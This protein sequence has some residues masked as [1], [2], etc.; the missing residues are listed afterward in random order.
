MYS[1]FDLKMPNSFYNSII[2]SHLESGIKIYNDLE[3]SSKK[4]L[5]NFIYD[6]GHIDGS[7]LKKHWFNIQQ[8]DIFISHSHNDINKVKA[9]AGWL[10]DI[11]GLKSFIDSCV[12]G[13]CNDLLKQI[14]DD[15]CKKKGSN[16]Y[17]YELR[18]YTTSHVHMMLSIA[19]SEMI[20]NAE[21]VIFYNTP[22][23]VTLKSDL[24][25]IN[26]STKVVTMSP[27]IYHELAMTTFI[28]K[29]ELKRSK[30]ILEKAFES[31]AIGEFNSINIEH[32]VKQYLDNM[33]SLTD[34]DLRRWQYNFNILTHK[35]DGDKIPYISGFEK[36]HPL[37]VLYYIKK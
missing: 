13:Y 27:W 20:D 21:C 24:K 14:D 25:A 18:N 23:S 37:D 3:A 6:N 31:R 8:A 29:S 33:I 11:F 19:L 35:V 10:Y 9:F 5:R 1:K 22:E 36:V 16:T 12:W 17:N 30:V 32:D 4:C 15:N 34:E 28:R 7:S 26:E 2:N